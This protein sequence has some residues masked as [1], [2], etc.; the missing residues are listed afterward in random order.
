MSEP[1]I[2]SGSRRGKL[3]LACFGVAAVAVVITG[4]YPARLTVKKLPHGHRKGLSQ[5]YLL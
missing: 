4:S 2:Q 1:H 3:A 5:P